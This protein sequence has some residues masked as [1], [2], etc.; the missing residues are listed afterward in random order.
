M[1]VIT[2]G[3]N[4]INDYVINESGVSKH[5]A[6]IV[7]TD[8][9][10]FFIVDMGSANGTF[11]NG[12]RISGEHPLR[13]G[14]TVIVAN[15]SIDWQSFF[16]VGNTAPVP[17][18]P[19]KKSRGGWTLA[20][21]LGIVAAALVA[22]SVFLM[23][24]V[25][26]QAEENVKTIDN[27]N[28]EK[29][30]YQEMVRETEEDNSFKAADL[31]AYGDALYK[32]REENKKQREATDDTKK[33]LEE[34]QKVAADLAAEKEALAKSKNAIESKLNMSDAA[35]KEL[36]EKFSAS[37]KSVADLQAKLEELNKKL[38]DSEQA[39][40][41]TKEDY[42][43]KMDEVKD[44][45]ADLQSAVERGITYEQ[46]CNELRF[47]YWQKDPKDVLYQ[48]FEEG[49]GQDIKNVIANLKKQAE[50]QQ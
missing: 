13:P 42:M 41:Q 47:D 3:R 18:A 40:Q 22:G 20:L 29:T 44:F 17:S 33:E 11:V 26:K 25:K 32:L 27:L 30:E 16:A 24:Y 34:A 35:Q 43:K 10:G 50:K 36:A 37:E 28:K 23:F 14:D 39:L 15:I 6:Q 2:I 21:I 8:D 49:K 38:D 9:G 5:H 45:S 1:K 7:K 19:Q 31:E 4:Q 48:K 12:K 46:I